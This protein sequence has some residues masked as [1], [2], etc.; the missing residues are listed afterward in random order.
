V[1][2]DRLAAILSNLVLRASRRL[3]GFIDSETYC[4]VSW[5]SVKCLAAFSL[6]IVAV[7]NMD[8]W[9]LV[10]LHLTSSPRLTACISCAEKDQHLLLAG[11]A[12][13]EAYAKFKNFVKSDRFTYTVQAILIVQAVIIA[14]ESLADVQDNTR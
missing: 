14:I 2:S 7:S 6:P 12:D 5:L 8:M 13:S 1:P 4:K 9:C 3:G 10:H 11:V